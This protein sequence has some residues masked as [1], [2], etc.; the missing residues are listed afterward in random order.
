MPKPTP[1]LAVTRL[2]PRD[3]PAAVA[4]GDGWTDP[5][6]L[7]LSFAP[8]G[9]LI[10]QPPPAAVDVQTVSTALFGTLGLGGVNTLLN[11]LTGTA[12]GLNG[13]L[14]SGPNSRSNT[15][16]AFGGLSGWRREILRAFQ[17][18]AAAT[19]VNIGLRGDSGANFG[20]TGSYQGDSRFGDIRIGG[21]QL[22]PSALGNAVEVSPNNGTWS[23]DVLFNT[24]QR[25]S[26]NGSG[27]GGYDL[28]TVAL[29]EAG[30]VF[31]LDHSTDPNS[32]MSENYQGVR[33]GLSASDLAT[34]RSYYGGAR[35]ADGF[36]QRAA[37]D[38]Q[39][40]ATAVT[41]GG[42]FTL[43]G[44]LTTTTDADWYSFRVPAGT[45]S[46]G[47]RLSTSGISLLTAKLSV[48]DATGREV[49]SA[50]ATDPIAGD[51]RLTV[52]PAA[53]GGT[54]YLRVTSASSDVFGVGRYQLTVGGL[55]GRTITVTPDGAN[56]APTTNVAPPPDAQPVL[57][58]GTLTKSANQS[59]TSLT[60]TAGGV[61]D[62]SADSTTSESGVSIIVEVFDASGQKVLSFTQTTNGATAS[63]SA[64]L[65][66]GKYTVRA[67]AVFP[68]LTSGASVQFTLRG[69]VESDPMG[70]YKPGTSTSPYPGTGTGSGG[71]SGG[72]Q[73]NT[74]TTS[75]TTAPP[76]SY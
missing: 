24:A 70:T 18:W 27:W 11:P 67:T 40:T 44:D 6:N 31:G 22:D 5:A 60:L 13:S 39:A 61:F 68:L 65:M 55:G 34:V 41:V 16:M 32:V 52:N 28:F 2:E 9:T 7:T 74:T 23:G 50:V 26:T 51:L 62:L 64:Y 42:N 69:G 73:T 33:T 38:T 20:S 48:V 36:D 45:Q 66:A 14:T 47:V 75:S 21:T 57:A 37:N 53:A 63:R 19:N 3:V 17:T 72:T 49:G 59:Q 76:Y 43:T 29:H 8:D 54:Y 56:P 35:Q 71:S 25:F 4:L 46:F 15:S 58:S 10:G 1:A 30:H 12:D